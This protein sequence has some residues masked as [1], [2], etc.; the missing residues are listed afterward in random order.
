MIPSPLEYIANLEGI[1]APY[2]LRSADSG[3]R[4]HPEKEHPYRSCYQRDRDRIIHC[5]AFR[6]LDYKTQVFV[7]HER[8]HYRT[9]MTHT[10]EVA[11]I[12]RTIARALGL[13]EDV[14]EAVALAHDLGHAPF[15]H[16]GEEIL[17][18]LMADAGGF[19]HNRQ[20]LRV[21]DYLEHPYPDFRG[22]NLTNIVRLCIIRHETRYDSA[23]MDDVEGF[24]QFQQYPSPPAEGQIVN[25]ADEIAYSSADL[26]DALSIRW[27]TIEQLKDIELWQRAWQIAQRDMPEGSEIHK[28]IAA[29]RNVLSILTD[30]VI[31]ETTRRIELLKFTSPID[32]QKTN[33]RIVSFSD[34]AAGQLEQLQQFLLENVYHHPQ[35]LLRD[36]QAHRIIR[37]LFQTYLRDP[38]LLPERYFRR[39]DSDGLQRVIC[40]YI[41][42]MTDRFCRKIIS[43]RNNQG[44]E[45]ED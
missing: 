25:L 10:L 33:Q 8:D 6:R 11:Q 17:N 30:D 41:A 1:L 43:D 44:E 37:E 3:G 24:E 31:T 35:A 13:N 34:T 16:A 19:E 20:S 14:V 15:G 32:I 7:P 28:R 9:R 23:M 45:Q 5:S 39:I 18:E 38:S 29:C 36:E 12:G 26:F 4:V 42:G 40:D 27:I 21:V 22:L 2:A